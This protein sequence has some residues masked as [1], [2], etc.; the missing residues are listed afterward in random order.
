MVDLSFYSCP[1][2]NQVYYPV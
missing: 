1:K 2:I